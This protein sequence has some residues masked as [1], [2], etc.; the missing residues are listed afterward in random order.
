MTL[1]ARL[2]GWRAYPPN[3]QLNRSGYLRLRL[4][5]HPL[6]SASGRVLQHRQVLYDMIGPGPHPCSQCGHVL[7]WP[8]IV[9][10]HINRDRTDNRLGNLQVVRVVERPAAVGARWNAG[11]DYAGG[12]APAPRAAGAARCRG[13]EG[14]A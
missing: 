13:P 4:P 9:V 6:A 5:S 3:V 2:R 14:G 11:R 1:L 10:D 12:D 8:K 7:D